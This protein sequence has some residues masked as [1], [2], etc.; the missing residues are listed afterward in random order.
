MSRPYSVTLH[1]TEKNC[2]KDQLDKFI[3]ILT[4]NHNFEFKGSSFAS[5]NSHQGSTLVKPVSGDNANTV[6]DGVKSQLKKIE[7]GTTVRFNCQLT[8][9]ATDVVSD[10]IFIS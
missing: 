5:D 6:F 4:E 1:I 7:T 2:S 8:V 10:A 3:S 9:A